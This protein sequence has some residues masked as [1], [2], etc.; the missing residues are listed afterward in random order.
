MKETTDSVSLDDA[1]WSQVTCE[2]LAV[3]ERA[4]WSE[5][6]GA[7]LSRSHSAGQE[8]GE[9]GSDLAQG[10]PSQGALSCSRWGTGSRKH[11]HPHRSTPGMRLAPCKSCS[12]AAV[13]ELREGLQM[14]G[15]RRKP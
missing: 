3:C 5:W 1:S 2:V 4:A 8:L 6:E 13:V 11:L 12:G 10:C 9:T 14:Y 15:W 7:R